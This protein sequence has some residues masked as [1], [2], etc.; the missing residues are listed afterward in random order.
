M[1]LLVCYVAILPV[2]ILHSAHDIQQYMYFLA[3]GINGVVM[4]LG[5]QCYDVPHLPLYLQLLFH[6]TFRV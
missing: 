2:P 6:R 1:M 3:W 4:V 5:N